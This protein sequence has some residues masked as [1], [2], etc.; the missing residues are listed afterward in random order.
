[1]DNLNKITKFRDEYRFLSNFFICKIE[2]N[3]LTYRSVEHAFQAQKVLNPSIRQYV[4][5]IHSPVDARR[6]MRSVELRP[7]WE[8]VKLAIMTDLVRQ[9]FTKYSALKKLLLDTD[10]K[11][12]IEENDWHDDYW[13]VYKGKGNNHLGKIIM[14][15]RSELKNG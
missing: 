3:G 4:S 9:K 14:K 8:V 1:M 6:Y 5:K 10:D 12:I 13:G 15:I 2:Y 7:D 11:E